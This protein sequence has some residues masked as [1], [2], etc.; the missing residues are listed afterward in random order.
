MKKLVG[1]ITSSYPNPN[2]TV[3]LVLSMAEAGMDIV[4]LGVPFSDPVADGAVIE[5]ASHEAIK[6]G[7]RFD[8][9]F[10]I[11]SKIVGTIDTYTMGYTNM[12]YRYGIENY[13]KKASE[14]GIKGTLI[15]DMPYEEAVVYA[16]LQR[17]H[18]HKF[19][20]FVA[21]T[22]D[23]ERIKHILKYSSNFVYLVA[24]AGITGQAT[25]T[26]LS[27]TI[28]NIRQTTDTPIYLGFGVDENNAKKKAVNVDGVIVGTAFVRDLLDE[29]LNF[30]EKL[31]IITKKIKMIKDQIC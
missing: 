28:A 19:V 4:E 18:N 17:Q 29:S 1:F 30:K 20:D 16:D 21:P 23:K 13:I 12:F 9:I 6:A 10:T 31:D 26:D 5:K 3:D 15:P 14:V 24:Y 22:D 2:F 11:S 8:D 27:Q 7:F 25:R